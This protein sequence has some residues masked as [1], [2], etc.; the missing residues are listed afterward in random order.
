M[1]SKLEKRP[2]IFYIILLGFIVS[3][4]ILSIDIY[5]PVMSKISHDLA[6]TKSHLQ[7]TIS[8]FLAGLAIAQLFSG[9]LSD[10]FGRRKILLMGLSLYIM[11]T[12]IC[13]ATN[14]IALFIVA[15][16]LQGIGCSAIT[17][18]AFAI[19]RDLF[20]DKELAKVI[21]AITAIISLI[22]TLAPLIGS[23]ITALIGWRSIFVFLVMVSFIAIGVVYFLLPETKGVTKD[24]EVK[25]ACSFL[26]VMYMLI[27]N[28]SYLKLSILVALIYA[29]YFSYLYNA[30]FIF[31]RVFFIDFQTIGTLI[32]VN[33]LGLFFGS[34]FASQIIKILGIR[35]LV[36]IAIC[37]IIVSSMFVLFIHKWLL[38]FILCMFVNTFS[39]AIVVPMMNSQALSKVENNFGSAAAFAGFMRYG[40]ASLLGIFI[41]HLHLVSIQWTSIIFILAASVSLVLL[42]RS[43][44]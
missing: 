28:K 26:E 29:S 43:D 21:A 36:L 33:A 1:G 24:A 27:K 2:A 35:K 34:F 3:L 9:L 19:S 39:V 13:G 12:I 20:K 14:S 41:A 32:A 37:T 38:I 40:I 8:V 15:R 31:E 16:I 30:T 4:P 11:M 18:S 7:L 42:M 22:P 23:N 6:T 25:Q 44:N 17:V 10:R 5:V